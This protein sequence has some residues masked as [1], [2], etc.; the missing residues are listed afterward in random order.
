MKK[1]RNRRWLVLGGIVLAG[2]LAWAFRP[3]PI[4]VDLGR[5]ERGPMEVT[6]DEE[7]RTRIKDR[8][9]IAAPVAGRLQRV[10]LKP[11]AAVERAQ[12]VITA[13]EP[14]E[15][16]PR[17]RAQAEARIS[18]AEAA[19]DRA[20]QMLNRARSAHAYAQTE[21]VR[22][23]QLFEGRSAS[24]QELDAAEQSETIKAAEL[25]SAEF[26]ARVADYELEQAKAALMGT[27][28]NG[29][30]DRPGER[31][32]ITSPITG[33]V[34]RVFQE[35][36]TVVSAGE[37][38]IEVGDPTDLEIEIEVLSTDAVKIKPG[39]RVSIEHWGGDAP[40]AARVR[41]VEPAGFTKISALGVEEQRVWVVADFVD[42]PE[43][44]RT[45]GDAFRVEA[46]I[47]VWESS[48]VLKVP[49]S[50]LFRESQDWAV[51]TVVDKRAARR[52]VQIGRRNSREAEVLGGL[53]AGETVVVHPSDAVREG[54]RVRSR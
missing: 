23:R 15:L 30:A 41:L 35:S 11:G 27:T 42:P 46:R 7:G 39:A 54:M 34:L 33:Y 28:S 36:S 17:A 53:S 20:A 29:S 47:V 44:R 4:T 10:A 13:I 3:Q 5:A 2:V 51:F 22:A 52:L 12:T 9:V 38:I 18:A 48:D 16:D 8:Y 45:I 26:E 49:A 1:K 6:V 50:A 25:R 32:E 19:R 31:F 40:L 21:L 43:Q 37:R 14:S 24:R